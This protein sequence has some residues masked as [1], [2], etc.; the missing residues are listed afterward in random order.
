MKLTR[1][2]ILGVAAVAIAAGYWTA[3]GEI[4]QSLLSDAVGA[5]GV[6]RVL[7]VAMGATGLVLALRGAMRPTAGTEDD[8]PASAH[9][10]AAGL[11]AILALY[12]VLLPL[13]GYVLAIAGLIVAVGAY[14]GAPRGVAMIATGI[15]GAAVFWAMFAWLLGV[16][17]PTGALR[18]I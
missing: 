17:M 5:D 18:W 8:L 13:L 6:P 16:S 4:Q 2:T 3:A 15:G 9:L 12:V 7:A 10:R 11:L 1:D 14:A